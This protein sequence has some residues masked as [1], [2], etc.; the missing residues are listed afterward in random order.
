MEGRDEEEEE[1]EETVKMWL[2]EEMGDPSG[3]DEELAADSRPEG[4][5]GRAKVLKCSG[6]PRC[7]NLSTLALPSAP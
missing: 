5:E 2:E 3:R 1:E 4:A 7:L 6:E